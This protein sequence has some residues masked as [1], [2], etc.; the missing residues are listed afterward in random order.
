MSTNISAVQGPN[1]SGMSRMLETLGNAVEHH[2]ARIRNSFAEGLN[3]NGEVLG[4]PK[5]L[6]DQFASWDAQFTAPEDR[7]LV[8]DLKARV[9]EITA[10]NHDYVRGKV[11]RN[12]DK[13]QLELAMKA[14]SKSTQGIQQLLSSQ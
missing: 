6:K 7:K 12:A 10:A 8:E 4:I 13:M 9:L 1:P 14:I 11:A 5:H 2:E 3:P